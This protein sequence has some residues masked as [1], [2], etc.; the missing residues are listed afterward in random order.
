MSSLDD[1]LMSWRALGVADSP[2]LEPLYTEVLARYSEPQRHYHTQ[3]HLAECLANVR[4]ILPLATHPAEVELALWFH[5]AIYDPRQP[6]N[7]ERSAAWASAAALSFG[8][9]TEVAQRIDALILCTRHASEPDDIDA[10]IVVDADLAILGAPADRFDE[11]E[12]QIRAEYY[13][14][15]EP[16]FRSKRAQVLAG[17]L[18]RQRIYN[19]SKFV[20]QYE[21][22]A[23]ENLL[24][25][26][27]TCGQKHNG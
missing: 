3:Q 2:R 5:D 21:A 4:T 9:Q 13:W 8:V 16:I 7:E 10:Q 6:D 23:R 15:A 1:W 18:A 17:F 19:T 11:Y 24:R 27:A 26:L 25:S 20:E 12:V 22:R 14:V